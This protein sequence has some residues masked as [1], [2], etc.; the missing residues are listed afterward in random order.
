MRRFT[1]REKKVKRDLKNNNT[2]F[3]VKKEEI[4]LPLLLIRGNFCFQIEGIPLKIFINTCL[5]GQSVI[6]SIVG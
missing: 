4:L 3:C 1:F 6:V 2:E 5:Q